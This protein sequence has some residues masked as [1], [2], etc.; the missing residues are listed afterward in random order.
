MCWGGIEGRKVQDSGVAQ[1]EFSV[2]HKMVEPVSVDAGLSGAA[3]SKHEGVGGLTATRSS[4][5]SR[6][7]DACGLSGVGGVGGVWGPQTH[8][9]SIEEVYSRAIAF[10]NRR[11]SVP[12]ESSLPMTLLCTSSSSI[13]A[14]L[15]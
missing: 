5:E 14:L 15:L 13:R 10:S 1:R 8:A 6:L 2:L 7:S 4:D 3:P 12:L 9:N 11:C